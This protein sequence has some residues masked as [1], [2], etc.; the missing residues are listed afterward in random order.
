M[1]M[2]KT[3][4]KAAMALSALLCFTTAGAYADGIE[5]TPTA[6]ANEWT[7]TMPAGDVELSVAYYTEDELA[8]MDVD[9]L[10]AAIG[11]V[12]YTAESKALIDAA[13]LLGGMT[14]LIVR[15]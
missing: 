4:C 2:K 7:F 5:V 3:I 13:R 8:A 11:E 12:A 15:F 6:N 10:I 14:A 1:N 9:A